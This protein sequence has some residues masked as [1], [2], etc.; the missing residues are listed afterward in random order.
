MNLLNAKAVSEK[1]DVNIKKAYEIIKQLNK[2]LEQKGFLTIPHRV[3]EKYLI[4]RFYGGG[5]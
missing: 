1:L 2:E 4:E 3:P 5:S